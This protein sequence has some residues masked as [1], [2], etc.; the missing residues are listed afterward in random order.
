MNLDHSLNC[1]NWEPVLNQG[2]LAGHFFV[3]VFGEPEYRIFWN[4][5]ISGASNVNDENGMSI[6]PLSANGKRKEPQASL[7][8]AG[9]VFVLQ[10]N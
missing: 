1:H 4:L 9:H 7:L 3:A 8:V 2:I 6:F 5:Q 10:K